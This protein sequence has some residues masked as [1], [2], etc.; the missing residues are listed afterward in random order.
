MR[1]LLLVV[2]LIAFL[3]G[4]GYGTYAITAAQE[5]KAAAAAAAP[6]AGAPKSAAPRAPLPTTGFAVRSQPIAFTTR[7]I[8]TLM[9]NES[10][11]IASERNARLVAIHVEEGQ[12]VEKGRLLF[13]FDESELPARLAQVKAEIELAKL[14]EKR[15]ERL[16]AVNAGSTADLDDARG[17]VAILN[18]QADQIEV[19][20]AKTKIHAP[21]AG[22]VGLRNVSIGAWVES[23]DALTT[24]QDASR[25]KVDFK[26]PEQHAREVEIGTPFR[27]RASGSATWHDGKVVALDPAIEVSTR[28]LVI[29]GIAA[30]GDTEGLLPGAFAEVEVPLSSTDA[31]FLIPT[32][33]IVPSAQGNS[34]FV[35]QEGV[36]RRRTVELG[37]RFADRVQVLDGVGDGDVVLITNLLRLRPDAPIA[38]SMAETAPAVAP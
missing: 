18:A 4:L 29:R 2:L 3:G 26:L 7:A 19:E 37:A 12:L 38:L 22:R 28:S 10:V 8:G 14:T 13:E 23:G 25:L 21:F 32:E 17:R 5:K 11:E 16:A 34:V 30:E 27:F 33:A 9:P 24:L 35:A 20:L 31:G 15:F 36:A 1:S 6:G